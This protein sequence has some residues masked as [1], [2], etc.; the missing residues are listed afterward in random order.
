V[1]FNNGHSHLITSTSAYWK[2]S[3]E[4]SNWRACNSAASIIPAEEG[5]S[6]SLGSIWC[7]RVSFDKFQVA[8]VLHCY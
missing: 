8:G 5:F 1:F 2:S 7:L 4:S 3:S 6:P